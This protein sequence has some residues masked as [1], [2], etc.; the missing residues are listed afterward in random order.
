M[1]ILQGH[2]T[3]IQNTTCGFQVV[4]RIYPSVDVVAMKINEITNL[5]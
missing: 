4:D 2:P 3:Q 1:V 5:N